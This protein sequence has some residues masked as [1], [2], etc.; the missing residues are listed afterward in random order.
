MPKQNKPFR[1]KVNI[2]EKLAF[3][4]LK[5]FNYENDNFD[6]YQ[7]SS[8][9]SSNFEQTDY[10]GGSAGQ[11]DTVDAI[12]NYFFT[13]YSNNTKNILYKNNFEDLIKFQMKGNTRDEQV[14]GKAQK[15]RCKRK[16]YLKNLLI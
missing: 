14:E 11:C 3:K 2:Y 1:K 5:K 7:S 15:N 13:V 10:N 12:I 16:V 4:I 6:V 8:V 9:S